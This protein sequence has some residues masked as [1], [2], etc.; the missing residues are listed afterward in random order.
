MNARSE[1][2]FDRHI[3]I[4]WSREVFPHSVD[5]RAEKVLAT[6]VN[7]PAVQVHVVLCR[8]LSI[9]QPD[10]T[11]RV[12]FEPLPNDGINTRTPLTNKLVLATWE[13]V[14]AGPACKDVSE[15]PGMRVDTY[16]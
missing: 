14:V 10:G 5:R 11:R 16:E 13:M 15:I 1:L 4:T 2:S 6:L 9:R 7:H 8:I 3:I 12:M